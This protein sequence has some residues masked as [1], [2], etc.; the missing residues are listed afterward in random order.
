MS[1]TDND[2]GVINLFDLRP[3]EILNVWFPDTTYQ[4][5]WFSNVMDDEIKIKFYDFLRY[6]ETMDTRSIIGWIELNGSVGNMSELLL[7]VVICLD[8]FSRNIYRGS[9]VI[10]KNDAKCIEIAEHFQSIH[11]VIE[12]YPINRRIF[13]LLPYR[14]QNTTKYLDYVVRYISSMNNEIFNACSNKDDYKKWSSNHAIITRFKNATFKNYS[15]V[16][17]TIRHIKADWI[18]HLQKKKIESG[19][20]PDDLISYI[21]GSNDYLSMGDTCISDKDS[22]IRGVLATNCLEFKSIRS[23]PEDGGVGIPYYD[24]AVSNS[25]IYKIIKEFCIKNELRDITISLSGGVDSMVIS[26]ALHCMRVDGVISSLSAVHVDYGNRNISLTEA[27]FVGEW[28][29]AL[30]IPLIIR[31]IE[32]MRR[33]DGL[34]VDNEGQPLNIDRAVYESATKELRF[35]LYRYAMTQYSSTSIMLGHHRDDLSENVLMNTIRGGDLLDL[36]TMVDHQVIDGVPI[37]R[38]LLPIG[39]DG[40]YEFSNLFEIPYL[41]DT[42]AES[43]LRGVMRQKVLPSLEAVDRSIKNGL[44]DIGRQSREWKSVIDIMVIKPILKKFEIKKFGV[45][46]RWDDSYSDLPS[47]VWSSIL[48]TIFHT[49]IGV[50]MITKNNLRQLITWMQNKNGMITLSNGYMGTFYNDHMLLVKK[51]IASFIQKIPTLDD[52]SSVDYCSIVLDMNFLQTVPNKVCFNGWTIE[53]SMVDPTDVVK[54]KSVL[55][56]YSLLDGEFEFIIESVG[57]HT[58]S[59]SEGHLT[60]GCSMPAKYIK[61][62][63][64]NGIENREF[65]KSLC[66]SRYIPKLHFYHK[67]EDDDDDDDDDEVKDTNSKRRF[68]KVRYLR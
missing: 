68:I 56:V 1:L 62:S 33:D 44:I 37:D 30:Q 45:M 11:N 22:R 34:I 49:N 2:T 60:Y 36:Y 5:F 24:A 52:L 18:G 67:I 61:K 6:L 10:Y 42:T 16:Q 64:S 9:D 23:K 35:N 4:E 40:I 20:S 46:I 50:K 8:Q 12:S 7:S 57:S 25:K 27:Q 31:R 54:L 29:R 53:Y 63:K 55:S 65:F 17:D 48:I 51:S 58:M 38:P 15:R 59:K 21:Y 14:H 66:L 47:I 32:H 19:L 28:C 39:K 13:Y 3:L 26:Y 43:C 41:K